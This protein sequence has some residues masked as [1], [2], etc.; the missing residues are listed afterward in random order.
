M[1]ALKTTNM[2]AA[3][4]G[5]TGNQTVMA[6]KAQIP[7]ELWQRL[8]G[9][10]LGIV[11]SAINSAYHQGKHDGET[12]DGECVFVGDQLIPVAALKSI[13]IETTSVPYS[14]QD[15][16]GKWH[17]TADTTKRYSLDWSEHF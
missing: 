14:R 4:D 15:C 9:R 8:T 3:Y 1:N 7:E 17:Q 11:M 5:F 13:K 10:E 16:W 2:M 6:I 12:V